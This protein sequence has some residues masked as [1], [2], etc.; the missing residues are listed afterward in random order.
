MY[1]VQCTDEPKQYPI[2]GGVLFLSLKT[3]GN[4][5][6]SLSVLLLNV[7]FIPNITARFLSPYRV[8]YTAKPNLL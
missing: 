7:M 3:A 5:C 2:K 8:I 1:G 4:F 6:C